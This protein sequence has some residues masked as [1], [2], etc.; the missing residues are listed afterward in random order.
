MQAAGR[1]RGRPLGPARLPR[2]QRRHR[3]PRQRGRRKA[4]GI[5]ARDAGERRDD[6]PALKACHP[7]H[8]QDRQGRR[9]RQYLVDLGPQATRPHHLHGLQGR[10]H[11]PYP[12][13]G[14]RSRQGPYPGQLHLPRPDV[15]ADGQ[16]RQRHERSQPR[17]TRQGLGTQDRRH[18]LGYRPC[19]AIPAEQPR[20]LHHRPRAGGRRRR[21][22]A[23]PGTRFSR[24]GRRRTRWPACPI[25]MSISFRPNTR[26]F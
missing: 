21:H 5:S 14:G 23:G 9:H 6:V 1:C 15:H 8:D 26:N 3:Q 20:P 17:P 12:G 22:A 2:Q 18:R 25:S 16:S 10:R 4:R 24:S 11:R 19:R 13:D 7:G